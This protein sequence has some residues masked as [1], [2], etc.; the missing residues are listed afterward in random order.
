[1]LF[2]EPTS[3]LD[4]QMTIEVCDTLKD[5][6]NDDLTMVIVTHEM[7][8]AKEIS[9]NVAFLSKGK[10]IEKASPE[11]IFSNTK[12]PETMKFLESVKL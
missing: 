9:D 4:P 2:D 10:I 1:M 7:S 3:A 12:E 8:L 11:E 6:A 5:L